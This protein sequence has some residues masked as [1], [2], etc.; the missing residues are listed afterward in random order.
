MVSGCKLFH[1][2]TVEGKMLNLS[3]SILVNGTVSLYS[4][5]WL[6]PL[7]NVMYS[8]KSKVHE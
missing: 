3:E 4:W 5:P 6:M 1:S 7:L 8:G 2:I